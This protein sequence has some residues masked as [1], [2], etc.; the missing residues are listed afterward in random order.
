MQVKGDGSL[1]DRIG[2]S[3]RMDKAGGHGVSF[4]LNTRHESHD[5]ALACTLLIIEQ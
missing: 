1:Y 4:L 5:A 2:R 3:G